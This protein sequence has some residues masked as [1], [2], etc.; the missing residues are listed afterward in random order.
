MIE[1]QGVTGGF[2]GLGV[3][4]PICGRQSAKMA[5]TVPSLPV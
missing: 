1:G 4:F 3:L 5:S 2:G